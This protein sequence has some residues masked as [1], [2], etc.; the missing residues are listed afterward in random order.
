MP[1][2]QQEVIQVQ[3]GNINAVSGASASSQAFS[4]S[5]NS[6]IQQAKVV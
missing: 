3:S 2:L 4:Q 1:I 6:A 5:L